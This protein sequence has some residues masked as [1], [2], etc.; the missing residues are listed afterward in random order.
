MV[1]RRSHNKSRHGCTNCKRRRVKCDEQR[2]NC[3]I[4]TQRQEECVYS[5]EVP[6]FFAGKQSRKPSRN[7]QSPTTG[8]T[9]NA[10]ISEDEASALLN[11]I[12]SAQISTG[13]VLNMEELELELQWIMQTHKLLARNEETRK[14]WEIMVLQE[15]LQEPFLMHGIL[16]LS[17]LHLSHLRADNSQAKWLSIAMSHK[18]VA[19]SMFSEQLSNI[20]RSNVK[21]MMS[22]AGLVVAFSL[23]SALTSGSPEGP[24]LNSLIEIFTLSRGVQAVVNA[25]PDFLRQSNFAPLFDVTAPQISWPDHVLVAFDRLEKLNAQCGQQIAHHNTAIYERVITY[26]RELAAFTLLQPTSMTLAGGFAIRA[27]EVY[28]SDL[29]SRQLYSLVVLAHYCG[30]LHM[31]QQ[32]WCVGSWGRVVLGEIQ[33]LLPPDWQHHIEWPVKQVWE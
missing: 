31:A 19:I 11:Q 7:K 20:D 6:Y 24:S 3:T 21:A 1:Y 13:P 25:E 2:P 5:S 10:T 26:L 33:Q 22:F 18:N 28:L 12:G 30:F 9:P 27:P 4:C 8:Q 23:G 17:A 29:T 32:N 15:A 14:V 16:G